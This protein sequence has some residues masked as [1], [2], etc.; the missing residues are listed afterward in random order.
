MYKVKRFIPKT[1]PYTD[2]EGLESIYLCISQ[3][4]NFIYCAEK[5]NAFCILLQIMY[6]PYMEINN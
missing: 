5:L 3:K 2:R 1:I 6:S 4:L